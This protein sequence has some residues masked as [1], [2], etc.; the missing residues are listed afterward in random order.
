MGLGHLVRS[1]A[2]AE[3][4]TEN[5]A[6]EFVC[7]EIAPEVALKFELLGFAVHHID[8]EVDF[9]AMIESTD[10]VV[11]DGYRFD[12]GYQHH[13]RGKC[14]AL[15]CIDDL[16][17]ADCHADLIINQSPGARES[18]YKALPGTEFALGLEYV[19]LRPAFL[20]TARQQNEQ[21]SGNPKTLFIC[22]GGSDAQNLTHSTWRKALDSGRFDRIIIVIGA[23]YEHTESL[24]SEVDSHPETEL[25]RDIS[26]DEM[27]RLM[28]DSGVKIVPSSGIL[29][30]A[31]TTGG[32]VLCGYYTENQM[33]N[34]SHAVR[35]GAV[36]DVG[37]FSDKDLE[38]GFSAINEFSPKKPLID[39][40][41]PERLSA[42]VLELYHKYVPA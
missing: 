40:K 11:L 34:H 6:P 10:L 15:I 3:M 20:H 37:I 28:L 9:L 16:L 39:G 36:I 26:A 31:L 27:L 42:K 41:S 38:Y 13:V 24:K 25:H 21:S 32:I 14:A 8:R 30:E 33:P 7:R 22:F 4:L 29:F 1:G 18:A 2:L 12:L 19:L 35:M 23:S 17:K 5:F